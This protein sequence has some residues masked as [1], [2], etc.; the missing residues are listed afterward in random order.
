MQEFKNISNEELVMGITDIVRI[1]TTRKAELLYRLNI[2][3]NLKCCGNCSN[4]GTFHAVS[5]IVCKYVKENR[6]C[7]GWQPD[8]MTKE[9]REIK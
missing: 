3:E 9:K 1:S 8:Q 6:C 4:L 7:K 2:Y 5:G